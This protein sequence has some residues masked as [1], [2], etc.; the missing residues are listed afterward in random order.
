VHINQSPERSLA[1]AMKA[2][3]PGAITIL[4]GPPSPAKTTVAR[5]LLETAEKPTTHLVTDSFHV[6]THFRSTAHAISRSIGPLMQFS[7][8]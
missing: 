4:S 1:S 3:E 7:H 5:M 8:R 2:A 6:A